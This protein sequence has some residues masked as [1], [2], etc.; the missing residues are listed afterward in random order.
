MQSHWHMGIGRGCFQGLSGDTPM[1]SRP[2]SC[3]ALTEGADVRRGPL[4]EGRTRA[5]AQLCCIRASATLFETLHHLPAL[6]Y[7]NLTVD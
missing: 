6:F 7:E 2:K 1:A 5:G 4:R 3:T